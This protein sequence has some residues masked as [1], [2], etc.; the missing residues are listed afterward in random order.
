MIDFEKNQ[1]GTIIVKLD[2]PIAVD[3]EQL[4]RLTIPALTGK[5]L[6]HCPFPLSSAGTAT[7]GQ[8]VEFASKIVEPIGCVDALKPVDALAVASHVGAALS[9][10]ASGE[11]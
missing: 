2:A 7:L 5:H 6:K 4:D 3:G 11:S 1:D 10:K 9:P 8:L